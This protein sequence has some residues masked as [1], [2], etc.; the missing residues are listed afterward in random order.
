[1]ACLLFSHPDDVHYRAVREAL[2]RRGVSAFVFTVE[3]YPLECDISWSIAPGGARCVRLSNAQG[4]LDLDTVSTIWYRHDPLLKIPSKKL[5]NARMRAYIEHEALHFFENFSSVAKDKVWISHPDSMRMT[6]RKAYQLEVARRLGFDIPPTYSGN[7]ALEAACFVDRHPDAQTFALKVLNCKQM[8]Y[9]YS[10][11]D[12]FVEPFMIARNT[13][14]EL[15]SG[16]VQ[17][18]HYP[19]PFSP[20]WTQTFMQKW[21]TTQRLSRR[22]TLDRLPFIESCPIT[23]QPYVAKKFELRI[24]VVGEQVFTCVMYTQEHEGA[25]IDFRPFPYQQIR[26][27]VYD[28]PADLREQCLE[29]VRAFD[30][31][32]GCIDMIVT[33]E[34]RYVFLEINPDGNWLWIEQMTKMPIAQ[35]IADLLAANTTR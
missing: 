1:L 16:E 3:D 14:R 24:T 15:A 25:S 13:V 28:L 33:P 12:W 7:S 31:Q 35:A 27:E 20:E 30:L 22:Q 5:K 32:F 18:R 23:L 26:H 17:L 2:S 29:L 6:R 4:S 11:K 21:V 9:S 19:T 8:P 10:L 34:G